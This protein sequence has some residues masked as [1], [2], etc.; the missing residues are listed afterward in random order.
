MPKF[1]RL[2][3]SLAMIILGAIVAAGA[4][5]TS[6]PQKDRVSYGI[7]GAALILYVIISDRIVAK[8]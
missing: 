7:F 3:L 6:I 8:G 2:A 1:K 5:D 4:V